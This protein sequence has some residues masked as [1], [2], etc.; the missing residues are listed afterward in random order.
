VKRF[1]SESEEIF[2]QYGNSRIVPS[3]CS[4]VAF[5]SREEFDRRIADASLVITHGGEGS[6]TK[7]LKAG[8]RPIAVPR[9]KIFGEHVND[10]QLE[11]IRKLEA[12]GRVTAVYDIASLTDAVMEA[13]EHGIALP[14]SSG[15]SRM[16]ALVEN[17][18]DRLA[19]GEDAEK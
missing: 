10:H 12:Q 16:L 14:P 18:L 1:I 3:G 15:N 11:L 13:R 4:S 17:F 7:C 19:N 2:V 5:V 8:K 6:I 9:Q